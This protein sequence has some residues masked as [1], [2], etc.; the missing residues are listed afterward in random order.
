MKALLNGRY[1]V[2][3]ARREA[4]YGIQTLWTG[5]EAGATRHVQRQEMRGRDRKRCRLKGKER[6]VIEEKGGRRYTLQDGTDR[7]AGGRGRPARCDRF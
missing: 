6:K 4:V 3:R 2:A 7:R 5:A 1:D